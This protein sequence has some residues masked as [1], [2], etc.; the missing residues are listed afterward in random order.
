MSDDATPH[1]AKSALSGQVAD[2]GVIAQLGNTGGQA[3]RATGLGEAGTMMT[4]PEED[5]D[6]K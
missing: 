3:T 6:D 1:P 4:T 2:R 5:E